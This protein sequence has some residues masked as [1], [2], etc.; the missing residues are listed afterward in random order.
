[1]LVQITMPSGTTVTAKHS[2]FKRNDC[3]LDVTVYPLAED[4]EHSEGLCGNF[5]G[6]KDDDRVPRGSNV[7][8][9]SREPITF[10]K[11]YMSVNGFLTH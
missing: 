7:D 5:N 6:Q 1:V 9:D 10:A 4:F 2:C 3:K 8:D 11:S